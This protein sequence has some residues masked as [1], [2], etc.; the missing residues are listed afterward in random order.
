MNIELL[1]LSKVTGIEGEEGNFK[2]FIKKSPRYVRMDKCIACGACAE[3]CPSKTPDEYNA[4]LSNRKAIYVPY[5]QAVPLKYAIDADKCIYFKKGKCKACEKLCPTMAINFDDK[6]EDI[7]LNVGS[8]V[9]T[10]GFQP[11]DTSKFDTYQYG[12]FPNVVTSLEFERILSAG[13]PAAGH[14]KR[15]SDKKVPSKIAWLQCVGSRDLNRCD[16]EYCSSVCCMY[17]IKESMIAKEHIGQGFEATIFY[18]DIRTHGKDFE[19]YYE[20]AKKEGLRFIR[21]RVHTIA[22]ADKTGTLK[23][24][25]VTDEGEK[26]EEDFDMVV[27]SVGMEPADSAVEAARKLDI[28]LDDY[29]FVKTDSLSPVSTSRPGIYVAGVIQGCKDIPQS[30]VEASAAACSA[31]ISLAPARGSSVKEKVFPTENDV[32]GQD[33][34]IGVFVCNCGVNIGGIADVPA[35]AEY[36]RGLPSVAHVQENLFTCSQDTQEKMVELIKE[37]KLNRI[38]VAACTPRTH[39]PLFQETIQNAGLNPYLFEMA[40]IRNQCTWCHSEEKERATDKAK[41]LVRMAVARVALL[42]PIP[43]LSVGVNKSTLVLGGGVAGMTSAISLADQG[44]PVT[45]VEKSSALGGA[46]KEVSKTWDGKDVNAFVSGLCAKIENHPDIKVILN[47]E[48]VNA[49]GFVGNFETTIKTVEG[50]FTVNHGATIIATGGKAAETEEYLYGKNPKVTLWHDIEH[51]PER[52]KYANNIVFIQCVGSRDEARP[53]CSRI[54]CTTSVMQ[55][56]FIK[57]QRPD[58][59][60]FILYRDMR[61][62]GEKEV[63]YKR[64]R[65]KGVVFIRY[66]RD[67]KPKVTEASDGSLSVEVFDPILQQ[68]LLIKADI[69]NLKTA[70]EP[71]INEQIASFYKVPLNEEKFF[72]EA[73]AKLRPVDFASDGL[74]VCGLAHY[75]KPIDESIEQAMAAAARAAT[76]L[77]KPSIMVSPLVSQ[78][79]AEVCIGCGLC[80]EVCAFGAIVLEEVGAK[81]KRAKNIPASCKGCG[82]CAASCPQKAIDMLHFRHSQLEA[83]ICAVA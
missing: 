43:A 62:Y 56:I 72:M 70:I 67:N 74:Y 37:H 82:L 3:K 69:L 44:F 8:V 9:L 73:H 47:S 10:A 83:S 77:S 48:V 66:A 64:A 27:L 35:I 11:F 80:A 30:V 24:A 78:V 19:K 68:N 5:P 58:A 4:N 61:T 6:E 23:L 53:Y 31:S 2:V 13:G 29:K 52:L 21:S 57:E 15:P 49:A 14:V 20:R 36:A 17:A 63:L 46:A 1:T 59:N 7:I 42:E 54:C 28:A 60:V 32:A 76:V 55:A 38:V 26:K 79:N 22:E 25:Y 18:M 71:S 12:K 16:N 41:D 75:P 34:R 65:E 51:D 39:E 40:N 81:G 50:T 45:I 33:P